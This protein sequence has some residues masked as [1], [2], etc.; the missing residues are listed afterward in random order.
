MNKDILVCARCGSTDIEYEYETDGWCNKC[1][2]F[3]NIISQ[4]EYDT[5]LKNLANEM[6]QK[7]KKMWGDDLK[8]I[9]KV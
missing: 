5:R 4:N 9:F 7:R 3:V 1:E 2:R 6:F 8:Y